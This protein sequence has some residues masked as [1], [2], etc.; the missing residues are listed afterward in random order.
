METNH[1]TNDTE[2][3]E[4]FDIFV[5]GEKKGETFDSNPI[6]VESDLECKQMLEHL[7]TLLDL[8]GTDLD[9]ID[10]CINVVSAKDGDEVI[11]GPKEIVSLARL[12]K[13]NPTYAKE[14]L[15]C[16]HH[17]SESVDCDGDLPPGF[18]LAAA[19]AYGAM[20]D[21][22]EAALRLGPIQEGV[23]PSFNDDDYDD[24]D[25]EFEQLLDEDSE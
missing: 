23:V 2:T 8:N 10:R 7:K 20:G 21:I 3:P 13:A 25:D 15:A 17:L 6:T 16:S 22:M 19:E 5:A 12:A 18:F 4:T 11:F 24:D 1:T 14:V 9:L